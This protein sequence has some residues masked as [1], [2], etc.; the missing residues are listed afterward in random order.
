[1][2]HHSAEF[3]YFVINMY[4]KLR[5]SGIGHAHQVLSKYFDISYWTL[6]N[7]IRKVSWRSNEFLVRKN[8]RAR[9]PPMFL[10]ADR[11][12]LA[13]H[14]HV[15]HSDRPTSQPALSSPL[16][17]KWSSAIH[18]R[19][20]ELVTMAR[21]RSTQPLQALPVQNEN[22]VLPSQSADLP[23][24][25]VC[26]DETVTIRTSHHS[27]VG[28][29]SWPMKNAEGQY[30]LSWYIYKVFPDENLFRREFMAFALLFRGVPAGSMQFIVFPVAKGAWK[31]KGAEKISNGL[32]FPFV[33]HLSRKDVSAKISTARL[34]FWTIARGLT[35]ALLEVHKA[36]CIHCDIK[37]DNVLVSSDGHVS[38][39]DFSCSHRLGDF[40]CTAGTFGYRAPEVIA[41]SSGY[42]RLNGR[43][44]YSTSFRWGA[45]QDVFSM[46]M[47][48][49][50]W[51]SGTSFSK[52][53]N[54]DDEYEGMSHFSK[55][56]FESLS[57]SEYW[58]RVSANH[59]EEEAGRMLRFVAEFLHFNPKER[60][61][62]KRSLTMCDCFIH[63]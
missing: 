1:M 48:L 41:R 34:F 37:P 26:L 14:R 60:I 15:T 13:S 30:R 17:S 38:V 43:S 31:L 32:I 19:S 46:G 35:R 54:T 11:I 21:L 59:G 63:G 33:E 22:S 4:L 6:A 62:L 20:L 49:L 10:P 53:L 61:S 5:R 2:V 50:S 18:R 3:K 52:D 51:L 23:M 57:N 58:S 16:S 36:G 28:K 40:G 42:L 12:Q 39:I 24:V 8:R 7:W 45:E 44:G 25:P 27:I 47:T 56:P 55:Q 29:W 9:I